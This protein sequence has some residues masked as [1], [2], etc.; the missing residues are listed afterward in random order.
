[1]GLV[2][3]V[4]WEQFGGSVVGIS[5]GGSQGTVASSE[6]FGE[7]QFG[8]KQWCPFG[9]VRREQFGRISSVTSDRDDQPAETLWQCP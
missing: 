3:T 5:S 2:G 9:T 4:Q 1:M 7:K 8:V 6:Q